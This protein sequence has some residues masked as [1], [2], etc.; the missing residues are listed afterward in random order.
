MNLLE[1]PRGEGERVPFGQMEAQPREMQD[2]QGH[3]G[4]RELVSER[5]RGGRRGT[6]WV[7]RVRVWE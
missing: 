6:E 5:V 3:L 1:G 7:L 2:W 4:E